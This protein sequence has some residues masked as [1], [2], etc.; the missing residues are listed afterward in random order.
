MTASEHCSF[1]HGVNL[2]FELLEVVLVLRMAKSAAS[3]MMRMKL[4]RAVFIEVGWIGFVS[5]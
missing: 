4:A 2:D 5:V 3:V 1:Y